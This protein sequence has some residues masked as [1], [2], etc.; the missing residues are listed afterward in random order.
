MKK[1]GSGA[2]L[3][4]EIITGHCLNNLQESTRTRDTF[5]RQLEMLLIRF[6]RHQTGCDR[7]KVEEVSLR[8]KAESRVGAPFWTEQDR[9]L[10]PRAINMR[11]RLGSGLAQFF[12]TCPSEP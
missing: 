4:T 3:D 6:V 8:G 9:Q 7:S 11:R 2:Y 10:R 12:G 5:G 1:A